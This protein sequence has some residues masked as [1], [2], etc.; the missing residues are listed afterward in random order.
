MLLCL[1]GRGACDGGVRGI[2]DQ[3]IFV[4]YKIKCNI[5][6][7]FFSERIKAPGN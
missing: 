1:K 4:R 2:R 3:A 5:E 7:H 6:S